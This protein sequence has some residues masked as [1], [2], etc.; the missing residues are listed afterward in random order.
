MIEMNKID[1]LSATIFVQDVHYSKTMPRLTK[2]WLG[3]YQ[4]NE[5]VF[6]LSVFIEVTVSN[7]FLVM[8]YRNNQLTN[9]NTAITISTQIIMQPPLPCRLF[10]HQLSVL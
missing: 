10:Q 8:S 5:L 2:H 4:D 9:I 1:P 6:S 7:V 3:A